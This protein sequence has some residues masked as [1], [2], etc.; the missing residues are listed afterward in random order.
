L[1]CRNSN[2]GSN[3][4]FRFKLGKAAAET[5]ECL[6]T[7]YGDEALKKTAVYDWF[8][9]FENG[10]ESLEDEER[11]GRPPTSENDEQSKK[12][13]IWFDQIAVYAFKIWQI[14]VFAFLQQFFHV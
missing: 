2:D 5:P 6:S 10:Q 3:V 1:K 12:F 11:S 7:V 13:N 14:Y 8:K 4:K 9:R